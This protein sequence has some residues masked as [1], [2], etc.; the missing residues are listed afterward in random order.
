MRQIPLLI[1]Q[2]QQPKIPAYNEDA[3][4]HEKQMQPGQ[5]IAT[6][7]VGAALSHPEHSP[8]A[9]LQ[10]PHQ[11][12]AGDSHHPRT[13]G[14]VPRRVWFWMPGRVSPLFLTKIS[15]LISLSLIY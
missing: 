10:V 5:I 3:I 4:E 2:L 11:H 8:R 13:P 14:A 1:P 15:H 6:R 9:G 12:P 7:V